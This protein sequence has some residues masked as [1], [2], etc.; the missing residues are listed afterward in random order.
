MEPR[1]LLERIRDHFEALDAEL[2]VVERGED[3]DGRS[4]QCVEL[5]ARAIA[6]LAEDIVRRVTK[7]SGPGR[8]TDA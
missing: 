2:R 8:T 1:K 4:R 6:G 3:R 7:A 5:G